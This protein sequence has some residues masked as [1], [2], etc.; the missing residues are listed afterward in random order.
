MRH[1]S[2]QAVHPV[3]GGHREPQLETLVAELEADRR[4]RVAQ[5]DDLETAAADAVRLADAARLQVILMLTAAADRALAEASAALDRIE[6]G[7]YGACESCREPIPLER[8]EVLPSSRR[9]TPCEY[10]REESRG[11]GPWR[12]S[13]GP[14]LGQGSRERVQVAGRGPVAAGRGY[15]FGHLG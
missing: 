4:F 12:P 6:H 2:R 10:R 5:L 14:G 3:S 7:T 15:V 8:L 1:P 9:C 11:G 13:A